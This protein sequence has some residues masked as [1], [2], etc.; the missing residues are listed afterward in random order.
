MPRR[1]RGD[2]PSLASHS[3][4]VPQLW[5]RDEDRESR[6]LAWEE[7]QLVQQR[8]SELLLLELVVEL[9]EL[10]VGL[11]ELVVGDSVVGGCDG[12]VLL[13]HLL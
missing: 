2:H 7:L 9:V 10:V 6:G 8:S 4:L 1:G 11:V 12:W 5:D 3:A 13:V